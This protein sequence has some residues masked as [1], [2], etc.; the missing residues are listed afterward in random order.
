MIYAAQSSFRAIVD[1][2][3]L[4]QIYCP[5]MMRRQV[6]GSGEERWKGNKFLYAVEHKAASGIPAV[7]K[8]RQARCC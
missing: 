5:K 1:G 8:V 4:T 3:F 7:P 2:V 6:G